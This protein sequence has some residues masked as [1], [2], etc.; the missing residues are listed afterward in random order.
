MADYKVGLYTGK[1]YNR[2]DDIRECSRTL[3]DRP[4]ETQIERVMATCTRC[5]N[6]EEAAKHEEELSK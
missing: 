2:F 4:T 3:Y 5:G 6:C 1:V